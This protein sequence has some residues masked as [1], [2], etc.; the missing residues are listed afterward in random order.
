MNNLTIFVIIGIFLIIL[1]SKLYIIPNKLEHL[2]TSDE[3]IQNL[4]SLYNKDQITVSKLVAS[5]VNADQLFDKSMGNVSVKTYI[6]N[7]PG[8]SLPPPGCL[9]YIDMG[10]KTTSKAAFNCPANS[11]WPG[12]PWQQVSTYIVQGASNPVAFTLDGV[13]YYQRTGCPNPPW[14]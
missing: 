2:T 7:K 14:C 12:L 3:A 6:D 8:P 1:V 13:T 11:P 4:S 10:S 5:T 9:P